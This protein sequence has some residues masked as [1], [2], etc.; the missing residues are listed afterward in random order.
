[1]KER[2]ILFSASM[3]HAI[4]D[5]RKT[6]TRRTRGLDKI[7]EEPDRWRYVGVASMKHGIHA[8]HDARAN[9]TVEITCPYGVPGDRLW[10]RETWAPMWSEDCN[11]CDSDPDLLDERDNCEHFYVEYRADTGRKRPGDWPDPEPNGDFAGAPGWKPSIH[12]PRW[13]SRITLEVT[14]VRAER[15]QDIT[16]AGAKAE[17]V[18]SSW[19]ENAR[20]AFRALW[21]SINGKKPGRAWEDNP[22]VWVVGFGML[23]KVGN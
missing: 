15:V 10:V 16:E 23:R 7:N 9:V 11:N 4:M 21:D 14:S 1:M 18:V 3:V 2:P 13:A 19:Y 20:S 22:W 17:G 12:M 5:G 6:E 8:F